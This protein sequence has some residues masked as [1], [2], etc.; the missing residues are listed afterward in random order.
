M[1][2]NPLISM[3]FMLHYLIM[4]QELHFKHYVRTLLI[5]FGIAFVLIFLANHYYI[6]IHVAGFTL[7][8]TLISI[9]FNIYYIFRFWNSY[10]F[11]KKFSNKQALKALVKTYYSPKLKVG[12]SVPFFNEEP[13]ILKD[14]IKHLLKSSHKN[15]YIYIVNDGSDNGIDYKTIVHTYL[16]ESKYKQKIKYIEYHPNRGKRYAMYESFNAMLRDGVDYVVTVDS[17]TLVTKHAIRNLLA[18]IDSNKQYGSVTGHVL[19]L[20]MKNGTLLQ[21][22]IALRYLVAFNWE[23]ASQAN[24][25]GINCNSGPLTMYRAN[26]IKKIK[27]PFVN[28]KFLGQH[29]TYGD[30]RHLTNLVLSLG[31]KTMYQPYAHALTDTPKN[32]KKY[33]KQQLRWTKSYIREL[34]WQ[35]FVLK[36]HSPQ[37]YLDYFMFIYLPIFLFYDYMRLFGT[38]IIH[39]FMSL[40]GSYSFLDITHTLVEFL[41]ILLTISIITTT[42]IDKYVKPKVVAH[43]YS[44]YNNLYFYSAIYSLFYVSVLIFLKPIA[45]ISIANT[46]WGTR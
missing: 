15:T 28:Q 3:L 10:N 34:I 11:H 7:Y 37:M 14:T 41:F 27:E 39:I 8:I 24:Y 36:K 25:G 12:V 5:V 42:Y 35:F 2:P 9:M 30:D 17:D 46:K 33:L 18:T 43:Q 31:L 4:P 22:L 32:V 20:N 1:T 19:S 45:I 40:I 23:R 38:A 44:E 16:K 26:V 29:T 21:K 13:Q 6:K